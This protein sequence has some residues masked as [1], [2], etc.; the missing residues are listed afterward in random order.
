MEKMMAAVSPHVDA[1]KDALG[2][3]G[4]GL[5]PV[6][7]AE[8]LLDSSSPRQICVAVASWACCGPTE[9]QA[10]A[11]PFGFSRVTCVLVG[12]GLGGIEGRGGRCVRTV[13]TQMGHSY[14]VC[15]LARSLALLHA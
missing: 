8:R 7:R 3:A 15:A 14:Q 13:V 4:Q 5:P 1:V 11:A 9:R 12:A 2:M 6:P 10:T